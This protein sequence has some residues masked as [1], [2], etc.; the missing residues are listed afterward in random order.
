M[1]ELN[2]KFSILGLV[3]SLVLV[4]SVF[5]PFAT[6]SGYG[7]SA[8]AALIDGTD[9]KVVIVIA[10][11]AAVFAFIN[12]KKLLLTIGGVACGYSLLEFKSFADNEKPGIE[13]TKEIGLWVLIIGAIILVVAGVLAKDDD[14]A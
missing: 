9:G 12:K 8:T 14:A 2:K 3:G 6:A 1:S 13:L 10:I 4:I 7:V 5:L 11:V